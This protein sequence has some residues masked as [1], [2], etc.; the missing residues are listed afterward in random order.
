MKKHFSDDI[1]SHE[2][3]DDASMGRTKVMACRATTRKIR[4][5]AESPRE[6]F[7]TFAATI[8]PS[9]RV[10]STTDTRISANVSKMNRDVDSVE[11]AKSHRTEASAARTQPIAA[12]AIRPTSAS[13]QKPTRQPEIE[14]K[15]YSVGKQRR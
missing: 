13:R 1:V 8:P 3:S 9:V 15:T 2:S 4:Y 5:H 7:T 14:A 11:T 12:S 6:W 10:P